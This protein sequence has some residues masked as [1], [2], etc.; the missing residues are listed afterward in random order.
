M[1]I[2]VLSSISALLSGYLPLFTTWIC[3]TVAEGCPKP[4]TE[5]E[6]LV[7]EG[8]GLDPLTGQWGWFYLCSQAFLHSCVVK[9]CPC[10]IWVW[11][12]MPEDGPKP[13][14]F[15]FN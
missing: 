13:S 14:L 11:H 1:V 5:T 3:C 12:T 15:V 8:S 9:L 4:E 10:T 6:G 7:L 2:P